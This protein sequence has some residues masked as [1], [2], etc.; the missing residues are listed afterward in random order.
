MIKNERPC[1]PNAPAV[2]CLS[3]LHCQVFQR[4]RSTGKHLEDSI[5]QCR[6]DDR[7]SSAHAANRKFA[8]DVQI[9][10]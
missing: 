2:E 9:P 5:E 4:E 6:I 3:T 7:S 8:F 1:I 10:E